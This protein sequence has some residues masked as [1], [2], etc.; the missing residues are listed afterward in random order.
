MNIIKNLKIRDKLLLLLALLL[1]PLVYFVATTV[2]RELEDNEKLKNEVVQLNESEKISDLV[3][4][5]QRERARILAA[6]AGDSA[7]MLDARAQRGLTDAAGLELTNFLSE[8]NRTFPA[9]SMLDDLKKYRSELD[10]GK[11]DPE[12]FRRYSSDF[13]F[14]MLNR[15]DASAIGINNSEISKQLISFKSLSEAKIHLAR[16]RSLLMKSLQEGIFSYQDYAQLM[17]QYTA[18]SAALGEFY[19]YGE[20]DAVNV[21]QQIVVSDEYKR[22]DAILKTFQENPETDLN[23]FQPLKVYTLFTNNIEALRKAEVTLIDQIRAGVEAETI[24]KERYLQILF[25]SLAAILLLVGFLSYYIIS[26]ISGSLASLKNAADRI[27]LG[28][29]DVQIDINST[30]EIGSVASSFRGVVKKTVMLSEVTKAIGQ[31][32]YDMDVEPQ[33]EADTL[34]LSIRTMK[35]NLHSYTTE[36]AN[37][38]WV[39]TGV[40]ELS[41]LIGGESTLDNVSKHALSYLCN[42]TDSEAG[43]LYLHNNAGKLEPAASYGLQKSKAQLPV[44]EVGTGTVGQTVQERKVKVLEGVQEE[45]LRIRTGL[46][47]IEPA[48]VIIMPLYFGNTIVGALELASRTP[49]TEVQRR[50]LDSASERISVLIHTLQ[51]HLHTQELLYET[52][53]QAEELETQQEELRQLN[54]EL[55]ASEE[56]LRVNQEE[57]QEKNAELEEKAQL[58]EE[59][60]EALGAKNK[61]LEDAREAIELK[62]QQVETVSKYKSDF[63]ANMSHELRTPL[64]SILI[65]SRLLADNAENTLSTK[66][67]DHAHIIHK[68]GNDLLR[69]INEI[70]DL[71]KIESGMVKLETEELQLSDISMRPMFRELAAKKQINFKERHIAGAFDSIVTDRFRLEQILKNFIGNAI[72]FTDEGGE[73]EFQVYLVTQRPAFRSEQLR[74]AQDVV[75][76][77]VRDTGIGIAQDKQEMVFEAF[78]QADTSTTRKYGGTGLGLTIS[79]EL[80]TLLGGELML[81]SEPGKGSTFTLYLPRVPFGAVNGSAIPA[82]R[83][84]PAHNSASRPAAVAGPSSAQQKSQS[85]GQVFLNM[86]R[87]DKKDICVLIVEDDKGFS[88]ILADFAKAKNFRV[89]QAFTGRDGLRMAL[90]H[91]PDAM[92]LDIQLPDMS[93]W[94]VLKKV[95]EDKNLRNINVHVMSAYDKEVIGEHAENEEYLPKPVTLEMLNKAFGSIVNKSGANIENILIVEDN[96]IENKAVAELLLAHGLKST[97]AYSAEEAEKVLAKQKV[98]C[99]I[100]DLN[101]PGMK[102]YDWMKRIKSQTK[103]GDI[104]IIIYSGKD[105]SEEEETKLKEFA[106]TIIIKNEYS[107]L[108]L[109]DE[110]QLFLH[111]VNQKLPPGNEFK[112]KLHVPEEVLRGKKILV[113]DDDVRNIYSLSSLLE[114]HGMQ[115]IAA[116]DGKEALEKLDTEA[117]I[118]MVLM[119]VMMPE[120]DG[121]EATKRIRSDLRFKQLPIISLTAKAMKEDREKC[122]EAGA[123]DYIP[124]PV[125]TDK[126]LTLMRVWLYEA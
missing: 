125:D 4:A 52:Q 98:D 38:N 5:F 118:D 86:E 108:R 55:K 88:D 102:G 35:E 91:K 16:M 69:L 120:M 45:Y 82:Q 12:D 70:L 42:Y 56:E 17:A 68:S 40:A 111:K 24:S 93:G 37:R 67:I 21:V 97:S 7:F 80:A 63:L 94:D 2:Q 114:L 105:L 30:D 61:A 83:Q 77:A 31:G 57:L 78:Q 44:F 39:L 103:L 34:S 25:A 10:K 71:S 92:L 123:S 59:Q 8:T 43:V 15:M 79:K 58:L 101:L 26:L 60:Y 20:K 112:M 65:L 22:G 28:A 126:L 104:P 100:L 96:D 33:S 121:I 75:A 54:A 27:R 6:S 73:V 47:D 32:R 122:I 13:I 18:H 72:K 110:V 115:V 3:H 53:N 48:T 29:T 117:G 99:I 46:T 1:F 19:R 76:F 124:K 51:A 95:R 87:Q 85:M 14:S 81:E 106:N 23:R 49:Y 11:L 66:Q 119:D 113:V 84:S 90:Q 89:H 107:Y 116:Y 36:N 50:L 62:I 109:L 64:N 9:L 41:N 74:E